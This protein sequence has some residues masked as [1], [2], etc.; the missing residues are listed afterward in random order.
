LLRWNKWGWDRGQF[1]QQTCRKAGLAP[2]EW[3]NPQ[4]QLFSFEAEAFAEADYP[5]DSV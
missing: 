5:P 1:L 3:N 2:D 4:A